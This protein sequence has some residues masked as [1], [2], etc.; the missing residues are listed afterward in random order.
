MRDKI[1]AS[2]S[3]FTSALN[4]SL[5]DFTNKIYNGNV[6]LSSQINNSL[7]NLISNVNGGFSSS[8]EAITNAMATQNENIQGIIN[9]AV[10]TVIPALY[11]QL[12]VESGSLIPATPIRNITS[13]GFEVYC[14]QQGQ[15]IYYFVMGN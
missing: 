15:T 3:Q 12:G 10:N 8:H 6:E 4:S 9:S 14:Q 13:T 1:N 11:D 2:Q 7:Q 5:S